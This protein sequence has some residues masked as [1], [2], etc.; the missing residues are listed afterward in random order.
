[1]VVNEGPR[2]RYVPT[3]IRTCWCAFPLPLK[4]IVDYLSPSRRKFGSPDRVVG[5][6]ISLEDEKDRLDALA[7]WARRVISSGDHHGPEARRTARMPLNSELNLIPLVPESLRP[8]PERRI[9]TMGKDLSDTGVGILANQPLDDDLYFCE[10][11]QLDAILLI[12]KVR[13]R[14][15]R[16]SIREY[17]FMILDR[18]GSFQDLR[19]L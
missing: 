17:G 8:C 11:Q 4:G 12:R 10:S 14:S 9:R 15:V 7:K 18:Y 16:G 2:E 6:A 3:V 5:M 19:T 1:M 13:D